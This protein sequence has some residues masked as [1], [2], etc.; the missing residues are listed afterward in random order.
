MSARFDVEVT[1]TVDHQLH[2]AARWWRTN[3]PKAP[4]AIHEEFDRAVALLAEQPN[5]G[6][7]ARGGQLSDTRRLLLRR[8]RYYVYYRIL[9][10][11]HLVQVLAFWHVSRGAGLGS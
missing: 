1:E 7:R 11:R 5:V 10:E 8:V 2:A 3:R 4:G 9:E 6:A